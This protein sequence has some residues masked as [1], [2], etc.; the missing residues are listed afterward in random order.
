MGQGR[1]PGESLLLPDGSES[2]VVYILRRM[3]EKLT[4][5]SMDHDL[6]P[7]KAWATV[8]DCGDVANTPF[9]KLV[10]IHELEKGMKAMNVLEA[11]NDSVV[12]A[13]RFITIGGDHTI[14]IK[15][16]CHQFEPV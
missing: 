1:E 7:F 14:S 3:D 5:E 16:I 13:T 2:S 6:N 11:K 9:D 8:V 4:L 10:A 15:S 12:D